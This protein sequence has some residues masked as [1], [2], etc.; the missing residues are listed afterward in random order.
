MLKYRIKQIGNIF[1]PQKRS[2]FFFWKNLTVPKCRLYDFP[3]FSTYSNTFITLAATSLFEAKTVLIN[4]DN[5]YLRS[6]LCKGTIIKTYYDP[7][8]NKYFY[9]DINSKDSRYSDNAEKI[10][11]IVAEYREKEKKSRKVTIHEY[12]EM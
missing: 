10:C 4:Y 2:F 7:E 6:F 9:V 1:Y 5:N 11:E 8:R 12:R 3:D